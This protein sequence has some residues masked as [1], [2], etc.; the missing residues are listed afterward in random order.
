MVLVLGAAGGGGGEGV[1]PPAAAAAEAVRAG[2]PLGR[3]LVFVKTKK[4][5]GT[6]AAGVF[7]RIGAHHNVSFFS[8]QVRRAGQAELRAWADAQRAR[9]GASAPLGWAEEAELPAWLPELL[10]GAFR[11][12]ILRSPIERAFAAF[13]HFAMNHGKPNTTEAKRRWVSAEASSMFDYVRGAATT[14][15]AALAQY[16]LVLLVERLPESL[17]ALQMSLPGVRLCD[18]LYMPAKTKHFSARRRPHIPLAWEEP[19]L[20]AD[21]RA[22]F[23]AGRDAALYDAAS[24]ALD[25]AVARLRPHGFDAR[26]AALRAML[27]GAQPACADPASRKAL[28]W[29]VFGR[30]AFPK[31]RCYHR[32]TGC[33]YNC[34]DAWAVKHRAC[35]SDA[36]AA[37]DELRGDATATAPR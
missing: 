1:P 3:S 12:T 33:N 15:R 5:G 37:R 31:S 8:P 26:V 16:D 32:D 13:Y 22:A 19:Q 29:A 36:V 18:V 21:V 28:Q 24:A 14:V 7:R 23:G 34:L 27:R 17:V 30:Q 11:A 2:A 4:C 9:L 35:G 6:T 25:A 20:V 10:P